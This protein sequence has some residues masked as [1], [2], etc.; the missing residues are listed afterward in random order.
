MSLMTQR[1]SDGIK[2]WHPGQYDEKRFQGWKTLTK[3]FAVKVLNST[4]KILDCDGCE[5]NEVGRKHILDDG[6]EVCFER[7]YTFE[8]DDTKIT[9]AAIRLVYEAEDCEIL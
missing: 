4:T 7:Y 9:F 6:M 1:F 3:G 2:K 5:L 8:G